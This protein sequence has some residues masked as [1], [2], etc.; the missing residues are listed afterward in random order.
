MRVFQTVT[1]LGLAAAEVAATADDEAAVGEAAAALEELAWRTLSGLA[2]A[3]RARARKQAA[4]FMVG[5]VASV[6]KEWTRG[7]GERIDA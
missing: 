2:L 1:R 6:L 7:L 3:P 5:I 4:V